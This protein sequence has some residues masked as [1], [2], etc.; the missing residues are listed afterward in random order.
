MPQYDPSIC[1]TT[2][3]VEDIRPSKPHGT[4]PLRKIF[5]SDNEKWTKKKKRR[6]LIINSQ[7]EKY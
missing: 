1:Y 2:K 6:K 4:T 7:S 3:V 5:K